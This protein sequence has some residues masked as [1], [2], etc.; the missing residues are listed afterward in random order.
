MKQE[1]RDVGELLIQGLQG[2]VAHERG[3]LPAR[4]KTVQRP[5]RDPREAA[6]AEEDDRHTERPPASRDDEP[7]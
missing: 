2:A 1:E 6:P 4:T 5:R 7:S 3:E